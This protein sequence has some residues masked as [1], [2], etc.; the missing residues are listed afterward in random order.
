MLVTDD[1]FVWPI[2]YITDTAEHARVTNTVY[3]ITQS[4]KTT[5]L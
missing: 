2:L 3:C 1:T 4:H 5:T